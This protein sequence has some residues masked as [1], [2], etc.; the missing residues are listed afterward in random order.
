VTG[1][2]ELIY[3]H[4]YIVEI[5][6][7][8]SGALHY[9]KFAVT[10]I[11]ATAGTVVIDWAYQEVAGLPELAAPIDKDAVVVDFEPIRF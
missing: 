2:A 6:E 1:T 8:G 9:A 4:A 5:Q 10:S 3:G 7:P 11:N